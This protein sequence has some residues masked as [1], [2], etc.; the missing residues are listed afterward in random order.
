MRFR[1][2][3]KVGPLGVGLTVGQIAWTI[4][5]H[6]QAIPAERRERFQELLR[7]SKGKPSNLSKS[8]RRE[9]RKLVRR[10]NVPQLVRKT[11]DAALLHS[12]TRRPS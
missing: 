12:R 5:Q 11:T 2:L 1:K 7:K 4:Q 3:R 6:W 10:L 8:E 9:L